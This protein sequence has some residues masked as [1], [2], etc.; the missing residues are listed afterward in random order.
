MLRRK[1]LW[2]TVLLLVIGI[3]NYLCRKK[4]PYGY[5][6]ILSYNQLY[7][8]PDQLRITG[9]GRSG[10]DSLAIRF[11]GA[12]VREHNHFEVY[13]D[14]VKI[15]DGE[16]SSLMIRPS[17]A[18]KTYF[19]KINSKDSLRI[20]IEFPRDSASGKPS[21]PGKYIP[22]ITTS[23][24]VVGAG[25]LHSPM[26]WS[27]DAP[28]SDRDSQ[29]KEIAHYLHDSM[30]IREDDNSEERVLKISKYIFSLTGDKYGTPTDSMARLQPMEQL[31]CVRAGLSRLYCGNYSSIFAFFSNKAGVPARYIE[32]GTLT[33]GIVNG[34][35][36]VNEVYLKEYKEW[37]YVD[38]TDG[39]VFVKK[40]DRFLNA[41]DIQRLLRYDTGDS[42]MVAGQYRKDSLVRVPFAAAS[43]FTKDAFNGSNTITF[44]YGNYQRL[45]SARNPIEKIRN[46]FYPRAYYA[47][48]SDNMH[49]INSQFCLRLY[50]TYIFLA[51]F[52][53]WCLSVSLQIAKVRFRG[54]S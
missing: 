35:H 43:F 49:L 39:I 32:S 6:D 5:A 11:D 52:L 42:T 10:T 28:L 1:F 21:D 47:L 9:I 50:S 27:A 38:L 3:L 18:L 34:P 48:Y 22:E 41:V 8:A 23:S 45:V 33:D 54:Q 19:I 7:G 26:D 13:C 40:K 17:T 36:V 20:N 4:L 14:S 25:D 15:S 2:L 30:K 46:F 53:L 24:V 31:N 44:Y 12:S 29:G 51:V 37:A 16:S